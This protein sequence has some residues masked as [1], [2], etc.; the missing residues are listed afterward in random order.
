MAAIRDFLLDSVT[1]DLAVVNGDFAVVADVDAVPQGIQIR[2]KMFLGEYW[3]DESIG[4]DWLGQILIKNPNPVAVRELIRLAIADT[5]D[6]VEVTGAAL[7]MNSSDRSATITYT[8]RTI[9]STTPRTAQVTV[10]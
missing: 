10:P 7:V 2:V 6:V 1:G 8:V 5:P 4:V 3:L 9:Y